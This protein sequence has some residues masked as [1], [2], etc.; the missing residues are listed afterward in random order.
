MRGWGGRWARGGRGQRLES[1]IRFRRGARKLGKRLEGMRGRFARD[2]I[3]LARAEHADVEFGG[4]ILCAVAVA[5]RWSGPVESSRGQRRSYEEE[6]WYAAEDLASPD[7]GKTFV[8][9]KGIM[10]AL[11]CLRL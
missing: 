4:Q 2:G 6:W 8:M 10:H 11:L 1:T 7:R 3:G 5:V 9:R